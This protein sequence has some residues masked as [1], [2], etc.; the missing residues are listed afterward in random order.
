[1]EEPG[2]LQSMGPQSRTRLSDFTLAHHSCFWKCFPGFLFPEPCSCAQNA[3]CRASLPISLEKLSTA[4][5]AAHSLEQ[6]FACCDSAPPGE[7]QKGAEVGTASAQGAD[8]APKA[9][10]SVSA[11]LGSPSMRCLVQNMCGKS[12]FHTGFLLRPGVGRLRGYPS[13]SLA[14]AP[15]KLPLQHPLGSKFNTAATFLG[16]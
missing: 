10:P 16:N 14:S 9:S 2:R 12:L 1:M 3:L 7:I 6:R 8:P 13:L 15:R 4:I 11:E 5:A